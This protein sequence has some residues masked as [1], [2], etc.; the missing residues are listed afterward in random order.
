[1]EIEQAI[2]T[3]QRRDGRLAISTDPT[4]PDVYDWTLG[5]ALTDLFQT[6]VFGD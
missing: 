2:G 3:L 4:D 1:M 6:E 5:D